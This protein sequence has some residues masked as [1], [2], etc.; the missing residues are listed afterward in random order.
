MRRAER[1]SDYCLVRFFMSFFLA[2]F[3]FHLRNKKLNIK[4][5]MQTNFWSTLLTFDIFFFS[6]L[7]VSCFV[8]SFY[9]RLSFAQIERRHTY[10]FYF[11]VFFPPFGFSQ[12][13]MKRRKKSLFISFSCLLMYSFLFHSLFYKIILYAIMNAIRET[14][15]IGRPISLAEKTWN[16]RRKLSECTRVRERMR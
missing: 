8:S 16:W 9:H 4:C 14:R 15:W 5:H 2:F 12:S 6:F 7:R 1:T 10:H 3:Q 11:V 13:Q